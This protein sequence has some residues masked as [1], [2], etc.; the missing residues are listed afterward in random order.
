MKSH[1]KQSGTATAPPRSCPITQCQPAPD[2]STPERQVPAV[3][4]SSSIKVASPPSVVGLQGVE[5]AATWLRAMALKHDGIKWER[6]EERLE[7]HR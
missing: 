1:T 4:T 6:V 3:S 7:S 2:P 5:E